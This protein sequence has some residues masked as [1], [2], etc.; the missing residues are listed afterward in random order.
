MI[1]GRRR[2]PPVGPEALIGA[3]T[4]GQTTE[5]VT[6]VNVELVGEEDRERSARLKK[7]RS[8]LSLG[9]S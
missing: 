4:L 9:S 1:E 3:G 5:S 8:E 6:G 2:A 7:R